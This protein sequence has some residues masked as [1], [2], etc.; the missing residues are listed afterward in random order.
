MDYRS[1]VA[2]LREY[3][4]GNLVH[5]EIVD[6]IKVLLEAS[7][8][9]H[10]PLME[11]HNSAGRRRTPSA[12]SMSITRNGL[13]HPRTPP[14][15]EI[16]LSPPSAF[17]SHSALDDDEGNSVGSHGRPRNYAAINLS[18]SSPSPIGRVTGLTS[19]ETQSA[20]S[21]SEAVVAEPSSQ[22]PSRLDL[23]T[24]KKKREGLRKASKNEATEYQYM[25]P[26]CLQQ[27]SKRNGLPFL[28]KHLK[29]EIEFWQR[30][31]YD[32]D[33]CKT[34]EPTTPFWYGCGLCSEEGPW[35]NI[36]E[37]IGT[38]V[39]R[40]CELSSSPEL[41]DAAEITQKQGD[42]PILPARTSWDF[43]TVF[44]SLM[45]HEGLKT[46]SYRR[47]GH[48][49]DVV[50]LIWPRTRDTLEIFSN[51]QKGTWMHGSN[52]QKDA[53]VKTACAAAAYSIQCYEGLSQNSR[54][55]QTT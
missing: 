38:H 35:D 6:A 9:D 16:L 52:A 11:R 50:A 43:S 7:P 44:E 14:S 34:L 37:M 18:P 27:F 2:L 47:S 49:N 13:Q 15:T 33:G 31:F 26:I 36:D 39:V 30:W 23:G 48:V 45:K 4:S 32:F 55:S 53:F 19:R 3:S 51:L 1:A 25:C 29:T 12:S 41:K 5:P 24:R 10:V 17:S 28:E 22:T 42:R 20:Q 46:K 21:N 8:T 40:H 54:Q